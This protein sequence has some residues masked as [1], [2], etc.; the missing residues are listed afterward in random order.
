MGKN[1]AKRTEQYRHDILMRL[2]NDQ[3][4]DKVKRANFEELVR[5]GFLVE[6]K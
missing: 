4:D 2:H 5:R 3:I 1:K 6:E